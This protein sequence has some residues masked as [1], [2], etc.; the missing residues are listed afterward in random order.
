MPHQYS[1]AVR[2]GMADAWEAVIGVSAKV[3][4]YTGGKPA[5][6]AAAATG[7]L[8]VEWPLAP[9]W[10]A[11][12]SGGVKS[13]SATP[14]LVNALAAG[15]AGYYRIYDS[16]GTTCHEQGTVTAPG[17][18]GDAILDNPTLTINQATA[19]SGWS[20]TMAGA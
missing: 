18:G 3:R 5:D 14:V 20:K 16:T 9:D 4:L 17:G 13:L 7:T 10:A 2:N 12:A 1:V 15:T 6:C 19:I 11:A 8:L